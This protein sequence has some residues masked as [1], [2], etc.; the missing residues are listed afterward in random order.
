MFSTLLN[1]FSWFLQNFHDFSNFRSFPDFCFITVFS[2]RGNIFRHLVIWNICFCV[3]V[4]VG[5]FMPLQTNLS[6][7]PAKR[8]K[9][10]N[11]QSAIQAA[12][13]T[14]YIYCTL[15][16]PLTLIAYHINSHLPHDSLNHYVNRMETGRRSKTHL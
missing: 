2:V 11:T 9:V 4:S 7:L 6:V 14:V 3:R 5:N 12:I 16:I 15:C 13:G 1:P 8:M 10:L